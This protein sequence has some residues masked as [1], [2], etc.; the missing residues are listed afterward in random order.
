MRY[1]KFI[2]ALIIVIST[3]FCNRATL[4]DKRSSAQESAGSTRT[5]SYIMGYYE[6]GEVNEAI[7]P[8]GRLTRIEI[9]RGVLDSIIHIVAGGIVSTRTQ[10]VYC[11]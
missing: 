5:I 11:E 2:L 6:F 4:I 3:G 10:D 1:Q 8:E 9:K 7:C